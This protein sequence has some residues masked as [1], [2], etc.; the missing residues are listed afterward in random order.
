MV[1]SYQVGAA[2]SSPSQGGSSPY[3][4]NNKSNSETVRVNA[5]GTTDSLGVQR[6]NSTDTSGFPSEHP[7]ANAKD[8]YGRAVPFHSLT[9]ESL[10]TLGSTTA[11]LDQLAQIGYAKK[12][13]GEWDVVSPELVKLG[14]QQQAEQ[15]ATD[16]HN[17]LDLHP[18]VIESH[19]NDILA[20]VPQ[21]VY[22]NAISR[23]AETLDITK[24]DITGIAQTSGKTDDEIKKDIAFI[25]DSFTA[26]VESTLG[27]DTKAVMEWAKAHKEQ[28]LK[29][30]MRKLLVERSLAGVK[31]LH[32]AFQKDCS[33]EAQEHRAVHYLRSQGISVRKDGKSWVVKTDTGEMSLQNAFN[34]G[35]VKWVGGKGKAK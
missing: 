1:T 23:F 29:G 11:T 21:P 7:L 8:S 31:E 5:D 28:D 14:E 19:L 3:D 2:D 35:Y 13:N 26:Q 4:L 9:G 30:A 16:F 33:T 17:S 24:L 10:V 27:A 32:K 18:D 22:D 34:Q 15:E 20:P 12:V 25:Q 6:F